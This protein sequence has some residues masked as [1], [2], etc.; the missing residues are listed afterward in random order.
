MYLKENAVST[1]IRCSDIEDRYFRYASGLSLNMDFVC[2]KET[3]IT[4]IKARGEFFS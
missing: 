1:N 2:F 3:L 4:Q